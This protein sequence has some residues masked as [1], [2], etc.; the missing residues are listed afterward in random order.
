MEYARKN[1]LKVVTADAHTI[2]LDLDSD[3][4]FHFYRAMLHKVQKHLEIFQDGEWRS[5]HGGFHVRLKTKRKLSIRSRLLVQACL[6]SDRT[7]EF[8][9]LVRVWEGRRDPVMLFRPRRAAHDK[10][11]MEPVS[12]VTEFDCITDDDVPF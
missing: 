7:K 10:L 4:D 8:L 12:R 3:A 2:L 9:S 11:P 6:G 5:E 1:N